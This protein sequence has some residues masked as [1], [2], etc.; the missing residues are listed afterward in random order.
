QPV[1]IGRGRLSAPEGRRKRAEG[2]AHRRRKTRRTSPPPR[3]GA[4]WLPRVERT[5]RVSATRGN[6]ARSI[7]RPGGA[8]EA[9][10]GQGAAVAR[11][12]RDGQ[13]AAEAQDAPDVSFAPPGR[14]PNRRRLPRAA[15]AALASPV[16]TFLRPSGAVRFVRISRSSASLLYRRT[17]FNAP[18]GRR[19]V[20]TGGATPKAERNPWKVARI[21]EPP[22]R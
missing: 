1:G 5:R 17:I 15:L 16:A 3:R 19:I 6:R 13:R 9:R 8:E 18:E 4:G 10:D 7:D 2:K 22:R 20:A 21:D 14:P 11:G 12:A